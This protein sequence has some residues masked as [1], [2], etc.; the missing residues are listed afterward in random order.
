MNN[1]EWNC[2]NLVLMRSDMKGIFRSVW[3][4]WF[5]TYQGV[6]ERDVGDGT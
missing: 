1:L 4:G 5:E 2:W 3:I 6:I